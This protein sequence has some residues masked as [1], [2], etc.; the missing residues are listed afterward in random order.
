MPKIMYNEKSYSSAALNVL[1]A[2]LPLDRQFTKTYDNPSASTWYDVV[3]YTDINPNA[4][5][6]YKIEFNGSVIYLESAYFILGWPASTNSANVSTIYANFSGHAPNNITISL[7]FNRTGNASSHTEA[8]QFSISSSLGAPLTA[9]V[10]CYRVNGNSLMDLDSKFVSASK[11]TLTDA[12]KAQVRDNIGLND[13]NTFK[14]NKTF[15]ND[16]QINGALK[17]NDVDLNGKFKVDNIPILYELK[18]IPATPTAQTLT[19]P[20]TDSGY[21]ILAINSTGT[22]MSFLS[23]HSSKWTFTAGG[24]TVSFD[25]ST[26]KLSFATWTYAKIYK[27]F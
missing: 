2:G 16:V 4:I 23:H 21:I 12:Q 6:L 7:R 1:N 14:G 18:Y 22:T 20:K 15:E 11:Q 3:N 17:S 27:W 26:N 8:I 19:L 9:K 5:Y 13:A 25:S 24:S 10:Y